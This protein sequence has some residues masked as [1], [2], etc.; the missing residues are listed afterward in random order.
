MHMWNDILEVNSEGKKKRPN[1]KFLSTKPLVQRGR[2]TK[3]K[4]VNVYLVYNT[5][6]T[7]IRFLN[8]KNKRTQKYILSIIFLSSVTLFENAHFGFC[9]V[10]ELK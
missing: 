8:Q 3:V 4:T 2:H 6:N 9:T 1:Q 7:G 10:L 5:A